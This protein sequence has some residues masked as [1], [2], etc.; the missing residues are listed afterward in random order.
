MTEEVK[1]FK[2]KAKEFLLSFVLIPPKYYLKSPIITI[3]LVINNYSTDEVLIPLKE[4]FG[5]ITNL[6]PS[7]PTFISSNTKIILEIL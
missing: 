1:K 6:L 3:Y 4:N 2:K 5:S 7:Y